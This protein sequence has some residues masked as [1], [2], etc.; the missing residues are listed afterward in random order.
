M[1][2]ERLA[3]SQRIPGRC[4]HLDGAPYSLVRISLGHNTMWYALASHVQESLCNTIIS[5]L[6][7]AKLVTAC[8]LVQAGKGPMLLFFPARARAWLYLVR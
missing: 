2:C 7:T 6:P 1:C 3:L 8:P 4:R 5:S